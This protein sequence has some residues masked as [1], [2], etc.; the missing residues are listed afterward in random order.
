MPNVPE[1]WL[2]NPTVLSTAKGMHRINWDLRYPDP[3]TLNYGYYGTLLDYREYTLNWH[4]TP[5]HTYRSTIV[6]IMVVPGTYSAKLTVGGKTVTQP[7]TI[8]PDP[9][10]HVPGTAL[11]AQLVLQQ[12]MV[13]GLTVSYQAVNYVTELR[14]ALESVANRPANGPQA[15]SVDS[16]LARIAATG[17][18]IVHRD[19]GRRYSDQF[20]ADA[21]PTPSVV[22][23]VDGP[24]KLLDASLDA[25]RKLQAS[26]IAELNRA[27]A[28]ALPSWV[29]PAAPACGAR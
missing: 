17:F 27:T 3:P 26:S 18:G 16:T 4:A 24:C 10:V 14:R 29:P 5:G 7:I 22:A 9:R 20:I 11:A 6:G 15:R 28:G 12:R 8:V 21:M 25:L 1:Y 19:L 23:G 13:A 2:A